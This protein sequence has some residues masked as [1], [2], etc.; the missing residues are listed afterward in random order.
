MPQAQPI[1]IFDL[2]NSM[3]ADAL[4]EAAREAA[5]QEARRRRERDA[6]WSTQEHFRPSDSQRRA[7][8][9]TPW[10][11]DKQVREPKWVYSLVFK[12]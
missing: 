1:Q 5:E 3:A 9:S 12:W 4:E 6:Q 7:Y 8:G 11:P 10:K 2:M